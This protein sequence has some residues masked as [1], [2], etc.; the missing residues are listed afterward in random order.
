MVSLP[1]FFSSPY[2]LLPSSQDVQGFKTRAKAAPPSSEW[3]GFDEVCNGKFGRYV[4]ETY[5]PHNVKLSRSYEG[6]GTRFREVFRR[7]EQENAPL[8]IAALGGSVTRGHGIGSPDQ[9][10]ISK[11]FEALSEA[12][13]HPQNSL[14]NAAIPAVGSR[15]F[16]A[17]LENEIKKNEV[18]IIFLEHGINDMFGHDAA[19]S[20]EDLVRGL[21]DLPQRP[22]VLL[23]RPLGLGA[24]MIANGGDEHLTV[25]SY[26]DVP[27]ISLRP[28]IL[29]LL[30]RAKGERDHDFYVN[31]GWGYPDTRHINSM[32]HHALGDFV[33]SYV[34]E[35]FA[36]ASRQL[37]KLRLTGREDWKKPFGMNQEGVQVWGGPEGLGDVPKLRLFSK[38]EPKIDVAPVNSQCLTMDEGEFVSNPL[39]PSLSTNEGWSRLTPEN[40]PDKTYLWAEN[41][42]STFTVELEV[43]SGK[44]EIYYL[45][46]GPKEY[47]LGSVECWIDD[48]TENKKRFDG[49]WWDGMPH[50]GQFG[51][52][53][54]NVSPGKHTLTCELMEETANPNG[55]TEF[56]I[57]S[58]VA[59]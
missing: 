50:V 59:L 5:S 36:I 54:E 38:Y 12:H 27:T 43:S 34:L 8:R 42:G 22:A 28:V 23:A 32:S 39:L 46:A 25:A 11:V 7:V 4:C 40:T 57:I 26:Y 1:S 35:Q 16:A 58:V 20:M 49:W 47:K 45:R 56:R 15:F 53:G 9:I 3:E 31:N 19:L 18:D 48:D 44:V 52:V 17:C 13:P 37:E 33:S 41:P 29:P 51:V 24:E 2:T 14:R 6:S 21:M 10:W 55:G 30:T